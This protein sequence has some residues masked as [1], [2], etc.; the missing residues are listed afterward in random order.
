M[1]VLIALVQS[2]IGRIPNSSY[3]II[4]GR[5]CVCKGSLLKLRKG[6]YKGKR[7]GALVQSTSPESVLLPLSA[8]KTY[9]NYGKGWARGFT[10]SNQ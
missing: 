6:K 1:F 8:F 3:P 4:H 7:G 5:T 9:E 10:F 2:V